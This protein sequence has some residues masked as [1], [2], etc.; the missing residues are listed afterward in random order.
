[1]QAQSRPPSEIDETDKAIIRELQLDGRMPYSKL[2]LR[3]GC[4]R[5]RRASGCSVWWTAA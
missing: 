4:H 3:S 1:M 5:P 2:G